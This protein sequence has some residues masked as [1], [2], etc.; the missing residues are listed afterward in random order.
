MIH[1][2]VNFSFKLCVAA[3][4]CQSLV[5]GVYSSTMDP[6]NEYILSSQ[7]NGWCLLEDIW[8]HEDI[9]KLWA[10]TEDDYLKRSEK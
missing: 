4:L 1:S 10:E 3:R 7:K 9:D 8:N 5:L 6:S 2:L